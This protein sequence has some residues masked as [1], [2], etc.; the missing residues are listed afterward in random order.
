MTSDTDLSLE[1]IKIERVEG[2]SRPGKLV[3]MEFTAVK[4]A[5]RAGAAAS[6]AR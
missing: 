3:E 4:P 5:A 2:Y 1:D 6:S